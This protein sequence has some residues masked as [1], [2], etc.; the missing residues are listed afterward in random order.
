MQ[1]FT[2]AQFDAVT[3]GRDRDSRRMI[4]QVMYEID[5]YETQLRTMLALIRGTAD[6]IEW[7][8]ASGQ[9]LNTQGEFQRQPAEADMAIVL[10]AASW[11]N[12]TRL[13][14][15]PMATELSEGKVPAPRPAM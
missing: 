1:T 14:G 6:R 2:D 11:T 12:L 8:L 4:E 7:A 3:A 10:R 5:G 13:I 9:R 15:Q